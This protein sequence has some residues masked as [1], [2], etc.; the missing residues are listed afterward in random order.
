[1]SSP[2]TMHVVY[3]LVKFCTRA[4]AG[5]VDGSSGLV[6]YVSEPHLWSYIS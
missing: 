1:M 5:H 4:L 6:V 2:I 3:V